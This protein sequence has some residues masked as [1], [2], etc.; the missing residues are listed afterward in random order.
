MGG[1]HDISTTCPVVE[2][3]SLHNFDP[4]FAFVLCAVFE[5]RGNGR[6]VELGCP[7]E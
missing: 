7:P 2:K 5:E 6:V 4:V 3:M 1:R